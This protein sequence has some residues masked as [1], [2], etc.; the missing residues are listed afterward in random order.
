MKTFRL[1]VY[2][3]FSRIQQLIKCIQTRFLKLVLYNN[4]V[5][6]EKSSQRHNC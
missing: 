2:I 4:G 1:N 6:Y 5:V 3:W